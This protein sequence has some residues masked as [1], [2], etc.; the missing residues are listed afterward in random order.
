MPNPCTGDSDQS[1]EKPGSAAANS[2]NVEP[3]GFPREARLLSAADYN[4]VFKQNQR[5]GDKYW[6]V[7]VRRV[8]G[9]AARLGLAVAKK[10]AKRAVDRNKLKRIAREAFRLQ[11][12]S[13]YGTELVVMNRDAA[14]S[15]DAVS[16]R[17]AFDR[18]LGKIQKSTAI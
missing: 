10:R 2:Q 17:R 14:A 7:L 9:S 11:Q 5:F 8:P 6:T 12:S 15:A 1:S 4:S 16:L 13:L 3:L 18:L